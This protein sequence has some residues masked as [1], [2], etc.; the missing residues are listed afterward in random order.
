[1]ST[2]GEGCGLL[3]FSKTYASDNGVPLADWQ[4]NSSQAPVLARNMGTT[5]AISAGGAFTGPPGTVWISPGFDGQTQNFGVVR[6][7]L[8]AGESGNYR[9][10]TSVHSLFDGTL[11]DDA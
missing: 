11:S 7:T 1:E 3:A 10:E 2:L 6:F 4:L 5:T 9:I 8:P